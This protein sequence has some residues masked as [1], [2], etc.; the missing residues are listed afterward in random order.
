M[1]VSFC[2]LCTTNCCIRQ[3]QWQN[4]FFMYQLILNEFEWDKKKSESKWVRRSRT[5]MFCPAGI[6]DDDTIYGDWDC[7]MFIKIIR[8]K[9]ILYTRILQGWTCYFFFIIMRHTKQ[10]L[11][12]VSE[13]VYFIQS[14]NENFD[15]HKKKQ[16]EEEKSDLIRLM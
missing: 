11:N 1:S 3:W 5:G 7:E 10:V 6:I 4:F 16:R 8:H 9:T 15:E 13:W 12:A 14:V 2:F